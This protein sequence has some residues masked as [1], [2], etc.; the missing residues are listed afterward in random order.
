MKNIKL[1]IVI[2][3][4]SLY[5]CSLFKEKGKET[6]SDPNKSMYPNAIGFVN[7]FENIFTSKE[8]SSLDSLVTNF[9]KATTVEIA[10]VTLD[11]NYTVKNQFD[12]YTLKLAN[13]WGVGKKD[14]NNGILIGI[15]KSLRKIRIQN[16]Y[17]IETV[18]SDSATKVIIDSTFIPQFKK[19]NFY[20]G[21][22]NGTL[23]LMSAV[24]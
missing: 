17:G 5:S 2:T 24:K 10:I 13:H 6:N 4:L 15:S 19:G 22:Y 8:K 7:D 23:K 18:L 21:T 14:K 1:L 9:E 3:S 20:K 12:E 16:G 11:T